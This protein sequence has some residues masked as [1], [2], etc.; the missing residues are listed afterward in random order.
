MNLILIKGGR[1]GE[2]VQLDHDVTDRDRVKQEAA[3]RLRD[4]GYA[5]SHIRF[6]ATGSAIPIPLRNF[7]MQVDFVA[8]TLSRLDPVPRDFA[9]DIYWPKL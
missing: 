5:Q 8:D 9:S 7:K 3:R 6:L 2:P 1:Y 4:A